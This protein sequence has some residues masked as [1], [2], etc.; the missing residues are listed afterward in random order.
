MYVNETQRLAAVLILMVRDSQS[1]ENLIQG[2][3]ETLDRLLGSLGVLRR[4]A[5][6]ADG[7]SSPRRQAST[8][9]SV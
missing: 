3:V 2:R 8:Y 7:Q 6:R 9:Q 4:A 5:G 1:G